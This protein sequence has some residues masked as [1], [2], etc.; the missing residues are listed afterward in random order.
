[1]PALLLH[2]NQLLRDY[3]RREQARAGR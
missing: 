3:V 1:V 2:A